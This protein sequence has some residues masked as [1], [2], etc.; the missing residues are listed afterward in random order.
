MKRRMAVLVL[1]I[2]ALCAALVI[3]GCDKYEP[4]STE[5]EAVAYYQEKYGEKVGVADA[6]GL[7]NYALFGYS[8]AG[9][10]YVMDDGVSVVYVDS[11]GVFCDNRQTSDIEAAYK[12]FTEEKLAALP[13][14]VVAPTLQ[15][16]GKDRYFQTYDGHGMCWHTRFDG[17]IE[18]FLKAELPPL[19]LETHASGEQWGDGRFSYELACDYAMAQEVEDALL[20]LS[21][22]FDMRGV[23]LAVVDPQTFDQGRSSLNDDAVHYTVSLKGESASSIEA[24]RFKP[25]FVKLLDGMTISSGTP[26]VT[27]KEGDVTFVP[28]EE[29][30]YRCVISS[31]I[32]ASG[33]DM[34]YCIHN[35]SDIGIT[36]VEGLDDFFVVCDP[37]QHIGNRKLVHGGTYF[38][39]IPQDI[40]PRI[41]VEKI[42][43]G[44]VYIRFHTHFKDKIHRVE[45]RVIGMAM[46]ENSGSWTST[47]FKSRIVEETDDGY[48]CVVYLP[49]NPKPD[50]TLYFQF[51]Y[52][53]D[54]DISLQM[55][56]AVQLD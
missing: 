32:T 10:E 53:D 40:A 26:G 49:K 28:A 3:V 37:H 46:S 17:D 52:N 2:C 1:A 25:V 36:Q 43:D 44:K 47:G 34:E 51:T 11:E 54:E 50:N 14:L 38:L 24:V 21:S 45:L 29:G 55:E 5:A 13:G 16:V 39:G 30:F 27:L 19:E 12:P 23:R 35:D 22:Y 33:E 18:A 6:H 20:A 8:Y 41:D 7:G 4:Q 42:E 56:K 48:R 15:W 31:A 9:M